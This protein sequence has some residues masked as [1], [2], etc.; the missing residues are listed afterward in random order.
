MTNATLNELLESATLAI[1]NAGSGDKDS[2]ISALA[3][4]RDLQQALKTRD[5]E[6]VAT[7]RHDDC[8]SWVEIA[9]ALGV[10]HGAAE[11]RHATTASAIHGREGR[12]GMKKHLSGMSTEDA[13]RALGI[14]RNSVIVAIR[15]G[16][17]NEDGIVVTS[18]FK[19]MRA[20]I[21]NRQVWRIFELQTLN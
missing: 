5:A 20:L 21:H 15:K 12:G 3:A 16:T 13:A 1:S 2:R 8:A 10:T 19:A 14:T 9:D 17:L 7:L 18:R 6:L 4:S 11:K